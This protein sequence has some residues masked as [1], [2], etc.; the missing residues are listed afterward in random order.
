MN[1]VK[2]KLYTFYYVITIYLGTGFVCLFVVVVVVFVVCLGFF[3][4]FRG[5]GCCCF[6]FVIIIIIY[7]YISVQQ[8]IVRKLNTVSSPTRIDL[9]PTTHQYMANMA[10]PC[11]VEKRGAI[12]R[13][14]VHQSYEA[15]LTYSTIC[16]T[17]TVLFYLLYMD[18]CK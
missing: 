14:L 4:F 10:K 6:L 3:V 15:F 16:T 5:G 18:H 2:T 11:S 13:L 8:R 17:K 1:P 7:G 12:D 9:G